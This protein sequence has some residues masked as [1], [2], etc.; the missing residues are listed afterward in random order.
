MSS[1][2][3]INLGLV[4]HKSSFTKFAS[5][6]WGPC[7]LGG[8]LFLSAN[9]IDLIALVWNDQRPIFNENIMS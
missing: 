8:R 4:N 3:D 2:L 7:A 5:K 6:I 1:P 9:L